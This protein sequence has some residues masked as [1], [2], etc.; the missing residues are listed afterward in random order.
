MLYLPG[1]ALAARAEEID[2]S[3]LRYSEKVAELIW[4]RI[5]LAGDAEVVR[6]A[7]TLFALPQHASDGAAALWGTSD[8]IWTTLG[9]SSRDVNWYTK[10]ATLSAVYSST[11]LYWLGDDSEGHAATWAFLDR[12]I[13][14]VMS[15]EKFKAKARDSK[16]ARAF[17]AGPG[18]ILET[19]KAPGSPRPNYPGHW[20]QKENQ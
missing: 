12:R 6:R 1:S 17:M 13:D 19:I 11:V 7:T 15:F 4:Q 2:I 9:D 8:L 10:R 16:L 20:E 5:Q 18:K 14:N 3:A